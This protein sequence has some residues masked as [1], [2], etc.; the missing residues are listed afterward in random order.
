[1]RSEFVVVET[2]RFVAKAMAPEYKSVFERARRY[3]YP[4]LRANPFFGPNI[5]KLRGEFA[6]VY[7]Y[8]IGDYRL[9]YTVRQERVVV[10]VIDVDHRK[11]AYR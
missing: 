6:G 7:R 3:V 8:R 2:E 4:Q 9:F 10:V 11:V 5:K 1:L